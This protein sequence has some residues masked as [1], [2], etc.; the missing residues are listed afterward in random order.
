MSIAFLFPGQGAQNPGFLHRLVERHGEL[1][2]H[3]AE[4]SDTLSQD[5]MAL[6]AEDALAS[7]VAVQLATVIAATGVARLCRTRGIRPQAVA[8]LSVGAFAAAF[9]GGAIE[10]APMLRMVCLRARLMEQAYPTG[11][12]LAAVVGLS[13]RRLSALVDRVHSRE[14]PVYIANL[15]APAQF[16]LAGKTCAL[17]DVLELAHGLGARRA[18]LIAVAVPS[19]C[20]LLTTVGD[21][22]ASA[23]AKVTV[24][25]PETPYVSNQ[26]GR[27]I[28]DPE[29]IRQDLARNV[30]H[31][32]LWHDGT[33]VLHEIGVRLFLEMP[34]GRTLTNLAAE[35]FDD[36]RAIAL[37]DSR[38]DDVEFLAAREA[39]RDEAR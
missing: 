24:V 21:E 36:A 27:L 3:F 30:M 10:F 31:P 35:A 13:L 19:H 17:N 5:V 39:S 25:A 14:R 34:P 4:A 15:N 22:L 38:L 32:V 29:A 28:S 20:M 12:G 26:G 33:T 16:V 6:D 8:G 2:P 18:E 11:H 23:M 1:R 7:T 9:S 37:E